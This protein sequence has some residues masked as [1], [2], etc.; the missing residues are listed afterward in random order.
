MAGRLHASSDTGGALESFAGTVEWA[1]GQARE[2]ISQYAEGQ[3]ATQA[4]VTA[5]NNQVAAYNTAAQQYDAQLSAGQNPGPRPAEPGAFSDPG[6]ALR[7]HAQQILSAARAERDRAGSAAA[8]VVSKATG[9]APASPGLWSQ[10]GDTLTDG[11]QFTNLAQASFDSGVLTGAADIGKFV[12]SVNPT[13]PWNMTHPAEYLAGLS[14]TAAGLVHDA[15]H[16]QDLVGQVL[17]G[18]WGSD[19]FEAAGKL[20]PQVALA[21]AT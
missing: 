13:D 20:V 3:Q 7:E 2:A 5:Y 18:G 12:R 19:P 9:L 16:P 10:V 17:G 21:V 6:A 15:V 11:A 8:S 1:Q 14:G 4:A